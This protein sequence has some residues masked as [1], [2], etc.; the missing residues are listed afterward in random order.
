MQPAAIPEMRDVLR[1]QCVRH[2]AACGET[3]PHSRR[4]VALPVLF[5]AAVGLAGLACF[6]VGDAWW[7]PGVLLL[8]LAACVFLWDRERYWRIACER[9]RGKRVAEVRANNPRL[10]STT[11]FDPF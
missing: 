11:N 3:T 10:G 7:I 9:C 1:R 2:C 5:A 4:V 8:V 6:P